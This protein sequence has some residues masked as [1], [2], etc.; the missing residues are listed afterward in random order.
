MPIKPSFSAELILLYKPRFC[1]TDPAEHPES[2]QLYTHPILKYTPPIFN[3]S[4]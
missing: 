2:G 1:L 3:S 4:A